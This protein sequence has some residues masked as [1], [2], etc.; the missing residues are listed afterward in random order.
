MPKMSMLEKLRAAPKAS[1]HVLDPVKARR[2]NAETLF[3]P[4]P[5]EVARAIQAIAPGQTRTIVQLRD[6]LV[7]I[8]NAQTACPAVTIK[9]WKW[10][11]NAELELLDSP[12]AIP[13]WR[14]LKDGR[15]SR[16]MPGGAEAQ[17][18]RLLKDRQLL[19]SS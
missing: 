1:F 18:Q 2:M 12:F 19:R 17:L 9:Y 16:H 11:A 5:E 4:S 10:M 8:G 13:W 7:R 14:V 6:D 15:P 3:I